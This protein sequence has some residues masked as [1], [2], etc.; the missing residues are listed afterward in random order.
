MAGGAGHPRLPEPIGPLLGREHELRA[1]ADALVHQDVR[2]LTLTGPGGVG[3]TR[4]AIE[5]AHNV[6]GEFEDG[7]LFLRLDGLSDPA[8]VLPTLSG[9]L[10][11]REIGGDLDLTER[12]ASYLRHREILIVLDNLEHLLPAATNL[13]M[14]LSHAPRATI[15]VTSREALRIEAE[16]VFTVAPLRRPDPAVERAV[17]D[18][19]DASSFPAVELFVH[20]A[21]ALRPDL[22]VDPES[23]A[24]RANVAAIAEI[25]HRLDGL[26]LAIELAAAQVQVLSPAVILGLLKNAGLS[27]LA[28]GRPD[29][30]ARLQTMEAAIAWS[31]TLLPASEQ[32]LFR[33]LSV[34]AGGFTLAAAAAITGSHGAPATEPLDPRRPLDD[35]DPSLIDSMLSLALKNLLYEEAAAEVDTAPRF[36]MLEPVRMFALDRLREAGEESSTRLRH[37]TFFARLA[38]AL[39]DL[40]LGPSPETWMRQQIVELDNF[41]TALD[42]AQTAGEHDLLVRVTCHVAQLWVLRGLLSEARQRI[43]RAILVDAAS[44][45]ANQWF[46]R[47]WAGTVALD[48]GQVTEGATHAQDLLQIAEDHN[49]QL[50]IGVGYAL[51]SRAVGAV[52]DQHG[53]AAALACRAVDTLEPLARDEWTGWGWT[54]LG[55]EYHMLGRLQEARAS[56]MRGL[57]VRQRRPCDGC[58]AY[59]LAS[60]GAVSIDLGEPGAALAAYRESLKLAVKQENQT[61]LLAVLMGLA[62]VAWR[63][64]DEPE[65]ERAALL[66]FGAAVALRKRHG[67]DRGAVAQ[68]TIARW[69][70]PIRARVGDEAVEALLAEGMTYPMEE[71]LMVAERLRVIER[72]GG[73]AAPDSTVSLMVAL[74]SIE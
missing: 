70:E 28:G 64:G 53:E 49:E 52:P 50:G 61:L 47:F 17:G 48:Q 27:L 59:S 57:E 6:A 3:K 25:C 14:V 9:A 26:P 11:L 60:L 19:T 74:G 56:L 67:L 46:L 7:V 32:K 43:S 12:I 55:I 13:M 73:E 36:R 39:D 18:T 15:L 63:C 4:L 62:D 1:I 37:A 22:A 5:V 40:T 69:Q 72:S 30:P 44:T 54:R 71:I 23:T 58:V 33:A 20:R 16:R 24:G 8:L 66:F 41:R 29:R 2:L 35:L 51:L 21:L 68:E 10:H 38:E 31:Y 42:W 65:P 34:F 45:P